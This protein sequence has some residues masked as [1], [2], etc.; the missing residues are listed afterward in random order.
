M[1]VYKC[2]WL[3][4]GKPGRPDD[5]I[6]VEVTATGLKI[7]VRS[8]EEDG[9]SPITC[10]AVDF[11]I[12]P[13]HKWVRYGVVVPDRTQRYIGRLRRY[14]TIAVEGL[15][16]R[17]R[18]RVRVSA[19]NDAGY[20][21]PPTA[22]CCHKPAV[23]DTGIQYASLFTKDGSVNRKEKYTYVQTKIYSKQRRKQKFR[24]KE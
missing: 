2:C 22:S 10:Y 23:F 17:E 1:T 24:N 16:T 7:L 19:V 21:G 15:D 20:V 4:T 14:H 8:P 18:Y 5:L 11:Q 13:I 9:G 6:P 3:T 12:V